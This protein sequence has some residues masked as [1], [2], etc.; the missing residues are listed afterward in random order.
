[1]LLL[2]SGNRRRYESDHGPTWRTNKVPETDH[3]FDLMNISGSFGYVMDRMV[4]KVRKEHHIATSINTKQ[5]YLKFLVKER[6]K[7]LDGPQKMSHGMQHMC[8]REDDEAAAR[9]YRLRN[10]EET[11]YDGWKALRAKD[12]ARIQVQADLNRVKL[13]CQFN[14]YRFREFF[15]DMEDDT[16]LTP[17]E[18]QSVLCALLRGATVFHSSKIR[19]LGSTPLKQALTRKQLVELNVLS[20]RD[21]DPPEFFRQLH[22]DLSRKTYKHMAPRIQRF[23]HYMRG[24]HMMFNMRWEY[25]ARLIASV[26]RYSANYTPPRRVAPRAA[27]VQ[28][29]RSLGIFETFSKNE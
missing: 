16:A 1:M 23:L 5:R 28:T 21:Y 10:L 13:P 12:L 17:E 19:F 6:L 11:L 7:Q 8:T 14:M 25:F 15:R 4:K 9:V 24:K 29:L 26:P 22:L 18:K 27:R 3:I 2:I 20:D